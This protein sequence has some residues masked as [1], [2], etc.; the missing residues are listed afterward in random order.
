MLRLTDRCIQKVCLFKCILELFE[1]TM[2][3]W[4]QKKL[5]SLL[6][7]QQNGSVT[8]TALSKQYCFSYIF[9]SFLK[10]KIKNMNLR[11]TCN[12]NCFRHGRRQTTPGMKSPSICTLYKPT[13]TFHSCVIV[14]EWCRMLKECSRSVA[15]MLLQCNK[16]DAGS[17]EE[18]CSDAT[19][20][21]QNA[22]RNCAVMRQEWHMKT[23]RILLRRCRNVAGIHEGTLGM[24]L[25]GSRY[26]A[27]MMQECCR[28]HATKPQESC[29]TDGGLPQEWCRQRCCRKVA[30]IIK[31]RYSND[32]EMHQF[33]T[34]YQTN[35]NLRNKTS[36]LWNQNFNKCLKR[37]NRKNRSRTHL[38]HFWEGRKAKP[39]DFD[40]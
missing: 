19:G 34:P 29:R 21:M 25:E 36:S 3:Q 2:K 13:R 10:S 9:W 33:D 14:K 20:M 27:E 17:L 8:P 24:V 16:N 37:E 23:V 31:G 6:L 39:R 12:K 38:K 28:K 11:Y 26:D 7:F 5:E 1:I 18:K 40:G 35:N 4:I 22:Y 32:A 30:G 15:K